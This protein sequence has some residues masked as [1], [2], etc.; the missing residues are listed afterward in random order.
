MSGITLGAEVTKVIYEITFKARVTTKQAE[1]LQKR[2]NLG[3][4]KGI[5]IKF[6]LWD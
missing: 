3:K 6:D 4:A 5:T 2:I 1:A